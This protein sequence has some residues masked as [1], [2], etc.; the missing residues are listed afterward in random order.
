MS[1]TF[2]KQ[3]KNSINGGKR[4]NNSTPFHSLYATIRLITNRFSN[5]AH[6]TFFSMTFIHFNERNHQ[7]ERE[8]TRN[9]S[10]P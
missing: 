5:I 9:T 4:P 10:V 1:E 3:K 7:F 6:S 8:N 2:Q